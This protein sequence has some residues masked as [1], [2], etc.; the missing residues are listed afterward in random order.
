MKEDFADYWSD[1]WN[2]IDCLLFLNYVV[3]YVLRYKQLHTGCKHGNT[4]PKA[5]WFNHAHSTDMNV[6]I[7]KTFPLMNLF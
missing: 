3:Y 6:E 5:S 7:L 2:Y 4:I 1:V